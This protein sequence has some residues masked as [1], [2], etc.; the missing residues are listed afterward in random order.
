MKLKKYNNKK[1]KMY[2]EYKR[3]THTGKRVVRVSI[4]LSYW[5]IPLGVISGTSPDTFVAALHKTWQFLYEAVK[6]LLNIKKCT[7]IHA[8]KNLAIM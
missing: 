6:L 2:Q 8:M 4:I 1:N 3:H 5:V 7:V